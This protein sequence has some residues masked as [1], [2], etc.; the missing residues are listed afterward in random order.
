MNKNNPTAAETGNP[1]IL[2][3]RESRETQIRVGLELSPGQSSIQTGIGFLDHLLTSLAHHAG[4]TLSLTCKGDLEVDDHHSA[5]DCAIALGVALKEAIADR[6]VIR[7]F[8]SA[9]APM[10]EALARAVVDISGRPWCDVNLG[11]EREYVGELACE[12]IPHFLASLAANAGMTLHVDVVKGCNDHHKAEAS[13][14]ALA[15]ALREALQPKEA[16]EPSGV[17]SNRQDKENHTSS[18]K[19][20][21]VITVMRPGKAVLGKTS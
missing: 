20:Q 8:G 9:Y 4:W 19:G 5:E 17:E 16:L 6:G 1:T 15:L 12:N 7:R 21:A 14:K 2:V 10:D 13:F 18:T 11:L 3:T